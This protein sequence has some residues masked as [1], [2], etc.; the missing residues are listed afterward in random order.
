M[1]TE[2]LRCSG[3]TPRTLALM[4]GPLAEPASSSQNW[5]VGAAA[6]TD[7]WKRRTRAINSQ[8]PRDSLAF[9]IRSLSRAQSTGVQTTP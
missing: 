3:T 1:A 6:V 4:P 8:L 9:T 7:V 5:A 2:T